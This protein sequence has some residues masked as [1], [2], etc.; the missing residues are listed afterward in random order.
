[1]VG[2]EDPIELGVMNESFYYTDLFVKQIQDMSKAGVP[3]SYFTPGT[4]CQQL[5]ILDLV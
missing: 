5:T 4:I 1:M 2:N 3:L